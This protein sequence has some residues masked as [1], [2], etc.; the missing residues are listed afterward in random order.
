MV[1][2]IRLGTTS[3]I[4]PADIMTNVRRLAGKV[5][6]IELVIFEF[7]SRAN[8]LPDDDEIAE[9]KALGA[10][11]DMTYTVHLPLGLGLANADAQRSVTE[12]LQ[13]IRSTESLQPHGF[14]VHLD[15]KAPTTPNELERWTDNSLRSLEIICNEVPCPELVCVENLDDQPPMMLDSILDR[16]PVSCCVDVGHL[17]K[18]GLDPVP[19]MDRWLSRARVVHIHG[20]GKRDHKRLSLI[21]EARLDRVVESLHRLF[22]G[23]LT[24]EVFNEQDLLDSLAA[25]HESSRRYQ[26]RR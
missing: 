17:W 18:Q 12:A 3:Y 21:P 15:G 7:D 9:L 24:L 6:D 10:A 20:V 25:F 14:I 1:K 4:Y 8:E 11:H 23:V 22:R 5:Q 26:Q 2:T 19:V 16:M 13:V